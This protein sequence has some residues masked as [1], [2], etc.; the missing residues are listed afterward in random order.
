MLV[1]F[2]S[3]FSAFLLTLFLFPLVEKE[4]HVLHHVESFHC[5]ASDQHFHE[6]QHTCSICDFIVPVTIAPAQPVYDFS[7][8]ATSSFV[9]SFR[10]AKVIS[11][12][13]YF[14]SLR[15]PPVC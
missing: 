1:R 10:E 6:Q 12:P 4:I 2:K 15:A 11:S 13:K 8:Y 7:I 3:V 14:V 9:I 5:K